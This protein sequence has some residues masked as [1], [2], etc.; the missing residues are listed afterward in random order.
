MSFE[1]IPG[2]GMVH[3]QEVPP[4]RVVPAAERHRWSRIPQRGE[5]ARCQR[6]GCVKCYRTDYNTVYRLAGRSEILQERPAC[7]GKPINS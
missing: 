4:R 7:T 3:F 6:C 2:V 5:T 1:H